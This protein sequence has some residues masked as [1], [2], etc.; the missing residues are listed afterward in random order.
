MWEVITEMER[1]QL[2]GDTDQVLRL[3][4]SVLVTTRLRG[5]LNYHGPVYWL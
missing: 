2:R 5:F 4:R 3:E 1:A